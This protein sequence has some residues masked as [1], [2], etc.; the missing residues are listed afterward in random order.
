[1]MSSL[2]VKWVSLGAHDVLEQLARS[3]RLMFRY[4]GSLYALMFLHMARSGL[5]MFLPID[6]LERG[7]VLT[8]WL[9]PQP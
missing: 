2:R 5:V 6:S 8:L 4:N 9:A 3:R 1:M 7:D